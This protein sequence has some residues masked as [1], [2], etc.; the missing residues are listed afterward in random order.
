LLQQY[1]VRKTHLSGGR[2]GRVIFRRRETAFSNFLLHFS[3]TT[4]ITALLT[5]LSTHNPSLISRKSGENPAKNGTEK[6]NTALFI[7]GT[8]NT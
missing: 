6:I 2:P 3:V 1:G 7:F 8:H 5:T 4:L